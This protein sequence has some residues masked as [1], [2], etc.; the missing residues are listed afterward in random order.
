M[1]IVPILSKLGPHKN[2]QD[3]K[4]ASSSKWFQLS[5]ARR[6]IMVAMHLAKERENRS[7]QMDKHHVT[8]LPDMDDDC[9]IWRPQIN[10][11]D[12]C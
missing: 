11:G 9:R 5:P 1:D 12:A 2:Q 8:Y 6:H 4:R 10:N 7:N 3:I